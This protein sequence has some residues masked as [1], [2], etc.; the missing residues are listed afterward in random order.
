M[1]LEEIKT[2]ADLI[3][4]NNDR[5]SYREYYLNPENMLPGVEKVMVFIATVCAYDENGWRDYEP[6]PDQISDED[7]N[8]CLSKISAL[9]TATA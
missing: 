5:D 6:T 1:R 4:F 7:L 8:Q 9:S 3:F 2:K